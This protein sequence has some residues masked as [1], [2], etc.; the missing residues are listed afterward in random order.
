[1]P[2][3][4]GHVLKQIRSTLL[5]VSFVLLAFWIS[6][7]ILLPH[8]VVVFLLLYP[9]VMLSAWLLGMIPGLMASVVAAVCAGYL[10]SKDPAGPLVLPWAE[11]V[12]MTLFLVLSSG[13]VWL[14]HH[15][16]RQKAA[17]EEALKHLSDFKFALNQSSILA[18]TDTRGVITYV[19]EKFC[20][21]SKYSR[22]ELIGKTHQIINS[23]HHPKAFFQNLWA[24]ISSGSV[25]RGDILNRA[26]DG[27]FYWVSTVIVP[28]LDLEGKPYQ[29][30][31]IRT[32]ITEK[33]K[34]E[35][36]IEA[37]LKALRQLSFR[38]Q[39]AQ[40]EERARISRE[41][42]DELGQSLTVLKMEMFLHKKALPPESQDQEKIQHY[43]NSIEGIIQS[44]RS[45]VADLRPA[46]LEDL[47][48]VSAAE[49]W[50]R[51]IEERTGIPCE[52]KVDSD[53]LPLSS[54]RTVALFRILQEA[55]TNAIRH[56]QTRK[57]SVQVSS[58]PKGVQLSVRDY[59]RGLEFSHIEKRMGSGL[60]GIRERLR[61]YEGQLT[62]ENA[63][64]G[65]L[66]LVAFIPTSERTLT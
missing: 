54:E 53:N 19:N 39:Q 56:S 8:F 30:M 43:I 10:L 49:W 38:L 63:K 42:H 31:A 4:F 44:V 45:V 11:K 55:V 60:A 18:T 64:G 48:L 61:P 20:E 34:S 15:G 52:L 62:L 27:S 5:A 12:Q 33:K 25:W 9:A 23:G 14:L 28:F 7:Y 13:L 58:S 35:Q 3:F 24:T 26:K 50:L 46:A 17:L 59:G 47:G 65:G 40:E 29:Y 57:I 6:K 1:M 41:I 22:E 21:I 36:S 32:D 16:Q 37:N 2:K 66:E 51:K